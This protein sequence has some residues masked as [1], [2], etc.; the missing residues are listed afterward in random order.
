MKTKCKYNNGGACC[1]LSQNVR[2]P[3]KKG[4]EDLSC[5]L[6]KKIGDI[7]KGQCLDRIR[8]NQIT[9]REQVRLR[10]GQ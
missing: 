4:Q 1:I 3:G 10:K 5:T 8:D 7:N 6:G 2:S 9:T